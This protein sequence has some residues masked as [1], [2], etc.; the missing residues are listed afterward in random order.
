MIVARFFRLATVVTLSCGAISVHAA[1]MPTDPNASLKIGL[2]ASANAYAY[3][4]DD[5]VTIMP[6]AFYDN[7]RA[8]IEGAEAGFYG[9]KDAKN[10]WRATLGYDS[11]SFTAEDAT[12][13]AVRLLDDRDW[14]VMAGTSYMRITPYGGFKGQVATDV[15]GRS[16]G[17]A[18]SLSHLSKF[19]LLDNKMT[20]YPELGLTWYNDKYNDYYFGVS[21]KESLRSGLARYQADAGVSPYFNI[22]ANYAFTPHWSGFISQ[23]LEWLSDEQTDSPLVDDDIDSKTKIGFNYQF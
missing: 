1:S 15:L 22:S 5:E 9:Y 16:E 2:N 6:Q 3:N 21:E 14:S 4:Q 13:P 20:L 10:Q 19:N 11:R 23:H 7:N 17:T 12:T 8:Y 18:V